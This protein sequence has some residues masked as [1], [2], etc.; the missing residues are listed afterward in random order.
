MEIYE[1][2]KISFS[3]DASKQLIDFVLNHGDILINNNSSRAPS[4]ALKRERLWLNISAQLNIDYP[5]L[6]CT[7]TSCKRHYSYKNSLAKKKGGK[8]TK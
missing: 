8:I 7:P 1:D 6:H 4:A 2:E 5:G 3:P